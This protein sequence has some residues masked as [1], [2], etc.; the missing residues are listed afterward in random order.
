MR[1]VWGAGLGLGLGDA[2]YYDRPANSVF[3]GGVCMRTMAQ[4]V[5][6]RASRGSEVH[7]FQVKVELEAAE[8]SSRACE[9][10]SE[11]LT[12]LA[13]KSVRRF[14]DTRP[15]DL[16]AAAG[17]FSGTWRQRPIGRWRG[18]RGAPD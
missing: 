2:L 4:T 13:R 10:P 1:E 17:G 8:Q 18:R 3:R 5:W 16:A 11:R 14:A 12:C 9:R 15:F 6:L 7:A